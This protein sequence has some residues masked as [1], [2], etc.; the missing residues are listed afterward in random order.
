M[1]PRT[2]P[3]VLVQANNGLH[4]GGFLS[5]AEDPKDHEMD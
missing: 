3:I 5:S 1:M 4:N 2:C